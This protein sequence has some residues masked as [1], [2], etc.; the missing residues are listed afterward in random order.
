MQFVNVADWKV[1]NWNF[2]VNNMTNI[3]V[4]VA[5]HKMRNYYGVDGRFTKIIAISYKFIYLCHVWCLRLNLDHCLKLWIPV[6]YRPMSSFG[7]F[8]FW[9]ATGYFFKAICLSGFL[10]LSLVINGSIYLFIYVIASVDRCDVIHVGLEV[11][12]L[13]LHMVAALLFLVQTITW[14]TLFQVFVENL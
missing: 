5:N 10:S 1:F 7:A 11:C 2:W 14:S 3:Y 8:E 9:A 4:Y 13:T 12:L 6:S